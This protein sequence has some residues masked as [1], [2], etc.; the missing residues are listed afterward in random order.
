MLGDQKY[1]IL[2]NCLAAVAGAFGQYFYKQGGRQLG[3]TPL[4][5]NFSIL[6]GIGLF[7]V[8]MALF[9]IGYKLGGRIS[10]VYPFYATTFV[11]GAFI[12]VFLENESFTSVQWAGTGLLLVGMTMIASQAG[13]SA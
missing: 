13:T 4:Y 1:P 11:W 12:G 8:V 5:Q 6:I 3:Q 9:V 7:C 10:V 2:M